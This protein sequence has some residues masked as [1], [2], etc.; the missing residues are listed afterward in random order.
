MRSRV[1]R[2]ASHTNTAHLR[3]RTERSIREHNRAARAFK[4]SFRR[5]PLQ[6]GAS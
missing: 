5:Y 1:L 3:D 2:H 6:T 4:W